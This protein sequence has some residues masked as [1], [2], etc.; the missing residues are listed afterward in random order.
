[1]MNEKINKYV[2]ITFAVAALLL[3]FSAMN[4]VD[5]FSKSIQPSAFR[6]FTVSGD[7]KAVAVPDVA[8]FSFSVFTQGGKN[9]APLM[10][11]NTD[12][13]NKAIAYVKA[14]GVES[15]DIKTEQYSLQPRYQYSTCPRDGGVCPPAE[16]VG[17]EIRQTVQVKARD[18]AKVGDI[19]SG[20]VNNGANEVSSLMFTVDDPTAVQTEA[21]AAAVKKAKVKA[22]QI[23][24]AGG[25][26]VGRLLSISEGYTPQP[27]Y[28]A[29]ATKEFSLDA[30]A[31]VAAMAPT[32]E[33][34]SEEV[35]INVTLQYEIK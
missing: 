28:R 18:F 20:V 17:Y 2:W 6:S 4:Y 21:R 26:S 32:V 31:G 1:M 33:A 15:K 5:A 34:G 27:Y 25:F 22:E 8:Q 11:E 9:I 29:Y 30:G 23:A 14:Q 35:V 7:G 12:K 16:I 13:M 24:R 10:K 19:L 3:A